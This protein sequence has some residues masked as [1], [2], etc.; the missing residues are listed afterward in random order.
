MSSENITQSAKVEFTARIHVRFA[1]Q[2]RQVKFVAAVILTF[3]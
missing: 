2:K 1:S 3:F